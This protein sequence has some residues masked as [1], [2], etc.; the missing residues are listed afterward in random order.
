MS[1]IGLHSSS[2]DIYTLA[3][4]VVVEPCLDKSDESDQKWKFSAKNIRVPIYKDVCWNYN[5]Q[6]N[7][8]DLEDGNNTS[9]LHQYISDCRI[10]KI[11]LQTL[12]FYIIGSYYQIC[13]SSP[14][15]FIFS[16][17]TLKHEEKH[18]LDIQELE[19]EQINTVSLPYIYNLYRPQNRYPCPKDALGPD[20]SG[21]TEQQQLSIYLNDEILQ[22]SHINEK[23][24]QEYVLCKVGIFP[25]GAMPVL[26]YKAELNA[27]IYARGTYKDIKK[28]II[29]WAKLQS[30]YNSLKPD[31]R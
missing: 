18:F 20:P 13:E 2:K 21:L 30:W 10:L 31:C 12:D 1:E 3:K 22:G 26:V 7:L 6:N 17:G 19:R 5:N 25:G 8:I 14:S 4:D 9:L 11:V 24:G 29:T 27:D 28:N 16:H 23:G 15:Q